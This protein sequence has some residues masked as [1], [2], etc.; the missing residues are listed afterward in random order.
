MDPIFEDSSLVEL[1]VGDPAV[2]VTSELVILMA[3][4]ITLGAYRSDINQ[5]VH[6]NGPGKSI[7]TY[8]SITIGFSNTRQLEMLVYV[9][10]PGMPL[11]EAIHLL[12]TGVVPQSQG[13][14]G[15]PPSS[16]G[17]CSSRAVDD[18]LCDICLTKALISST[19]DCDC[20]LEES[21]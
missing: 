20:L 5:T 19:L 15:S 17:L 1:A 21:S 10:G 4:A 11:D 8:T 18:S 9:P 2:Q 7:T 13:A 16:S 12:S 3:T 14:P 6:C